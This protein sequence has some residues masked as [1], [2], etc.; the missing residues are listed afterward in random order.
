MA[1]KWIVRGTDNTSLYGVFDESGEMRSTHRLKEDAQKMASLPML[2]SA[3]RESYA[4][5][6][7][8]ARRF[9]IVPESDMT[10]RIVA[11]IAAAEGGE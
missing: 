8:V 10:E 4:Y 2:H 1:E 6:I 3:L 5:I 9:N 7:E 11:A